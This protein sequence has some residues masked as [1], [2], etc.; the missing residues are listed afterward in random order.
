[1]IVPLFTTPCPQYW[2]WTWTTCFV[3]SSFTDP[4]MEYDGG[5][6]T[7]RLYESSKATSFSCRFSPQHRRNTIYAKKGRS[8]L[9]MTALSEMSPLRPVCLDLVVN[10]GIEKFLDSFVHLSSLLGRQWR[11]DVVRVWQCINQTTMET[12]GHSTMETRGYYFRR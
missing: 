2:N 11:A 5:R 6:S 12:R 4:T 1:M 8:L 7:P 9:K 3:L 10:T